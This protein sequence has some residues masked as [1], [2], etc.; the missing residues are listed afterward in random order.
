MWGPGNLQRPARCSRLLPSQPFP[1]SRSSVCVRMGQSQPHPPPAQPGLLGSRAYC[2][3]Q[4]G[5]PLAG[6]SWAHLLATGSPASPAPSQLPGASSSSSGPWSRLLSAAWLPT[7]TPAEG[8]PSGRQPPDR[9]CAVPW[10][11]RAL[12]RAPGWDPRT[13]STYPALASL[14]AAP[15][16]LP[17]LLAGAHTLTLRGRQEAAEGREGW[18]MAAPRPRPGS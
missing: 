17:H 15:A 18:P 1:G 3:H 4:G 10:L 9:L 5:G 14:A 12:P 6:Q 16:L 7:R 8:T 13:P 2:G 11:L